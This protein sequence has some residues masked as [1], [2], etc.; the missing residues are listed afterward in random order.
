[1]KCRILV[2]FILIGFQPIIRGQNDLPDSL[3]LSFH[4]QLLFFPQ[5]K[6]HLHT[7]KS[8][9][10]S[11]EHIWFRAHLVDAAT[12]IPATAS[13]YVY[14]ELINPL[15]TVVTRVKI[16]QDE[17]G[18]YYGHLL[19]PAVAPEG[20]YTIRAYTAFMRSL[21][22]DYFFTKTIRIGD[23]Q[24]CV[25][26]TETQFTFESG[27]R[28]NVAIRFS[29]V[30]SAAPL[31][32]KSLKAG[33]NGGKKMNVAVDDNG[34]AGIN[35]PAVTGKN[36]IL[37]E[38]SFNNNPYRKF[39]LAPLP[40]DDFD[41]SFYP[42]GGSLMQGALC[43]VAFKAMKSNGQ[44]A[45]ITGVVYDYTGVELQRFESHHLG[46]GNFSL[47][48]EKGKKYYAICE[49]DKGQ[50][51]R[52]DLPVAVDY[53]YAL[54]INRLGGK[55]YVTT[56]KP[57]VPAYLSELSKSAEFEKPLYLLGHIRG[58]VYFADLWNPE[59]PLVLVPE[60][61]PSGVMHIVLFD[62]DLKPISERLIFI[63]NQDQ[64]QVTYQPDQ[65]NFTRRSLVKNKIILTDSDGEPLSG[66]FSVSV[67]SDREITPDST[68]NILTQLLLSSE[69]RGNIENAVFYFQNASFSAHALDL[70]MSTQGWRRYDIA[71]LAQ[72]RFLLPT[73]PLEIGSEIS[74]SVKSLLLGKPVEDIE[75]TA[76]SMAGGFFDHAKTDKNGRF[77][78]YGGELPDSTLFIISAIPKRGIT[79]LEL[80]L[81]RE[82]F[83]GRRLSTVPFAEIDRYQFAKFVDKAEQKYIEEHG[84]RVN[85]LTE[86]IISAERKKPVINTIYNTPVTPV[87]TFTVEDIN[88]DRPRNIFDLL[89]RVHGYNP[90]TGTFRGQGSILLSGAPLFVV[91]GMPTTY[92]PEMHLIEQVDVLKGTE[93]SLY[94]SR[95]SNGVIVIHTKNGGAEKREIPAYHL[96]EFF[97]LGYQESVEF[98]AP[99]YDTPEKQRNRIS[100]LRTTIHWQPVVQAD[101]LGVA[102]FEFYTADEETSY[103]VVIEGIANNGNIIRKEERMWKNEE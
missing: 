50:S 66:N 61:F 16:L 29:H 92:M 93:I 23:P 103:S 18:A 34:V 94:G 67:T 6:I 51:K 101:S 37:L 4:R 48:A 75:V 36:V 17:G 95:G 99:K 1:M 73:F 70:L 19:I 13:R 53:G 35:I 76:M 32:P 33:V 87:A 79:Q 90:S 77:S 42:E 81:D 54:K 3:V 62:A 46:M 43:I 22:E 100:D 28:M 55:I 96:Q 72:G 88:R 45:N 102:S 97:P 84:G 7:D 64:A 68:S 26:H 63:N 98:Y 31:L 85:L 5:E 12:H 41:V 25:I 57:D 44:A 38:T 2:F 39:V 78:L 8:Y 14:V 58:K 74:G 15:D 71:E 21:D 10:I 80:I 82:T 89:E 27:S 9:Y 65:A 91:D 49:N 86:V 20:D 69:L 56:L 30:G 24:S 59:S 83:P 52:F 40:D 11:G 60:Q 47:L